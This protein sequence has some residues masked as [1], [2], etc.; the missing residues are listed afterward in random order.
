MAEWRNGVPAGADLI[1]NVFAVGYDN[2]A[3]AKSRFLGITTI[4]NRSDLVTAPPVERVV[5][6]N[7]LM[8][9]QSI[10]FCGAI[11]HDLSRGL[12]VSAEWQGRNPNQ[13]R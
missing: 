10:D 6:K 1:S 2:S 8:S 5:R 9:G 12:R 3:L 13:R 7:I 11:H 4:D